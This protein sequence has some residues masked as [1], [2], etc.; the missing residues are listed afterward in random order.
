MEAL[1]FC[2]RVLF[3]AYVCSL[4]LVMFFPFFFFFFFFFFF[5]IFF[6]LFVNSFSFRRF[7]KVSVYIFLVV[8]NGFVHR[9]VCVFLTVFG[10][11]C[12]FSL[13]LLET[14]FQFCS[15]FLVLIWLF[16]SLLF[17][18]EPRVVLSSMSGFALVLLL[19]ICLGCSTSSGF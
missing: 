3:C 6:L 19:Y 16:C 10:G 14:F 13:C 12:A 15:A 18:V 9:C 8:V 5:V 11:L 2:C 7:L 1:F 4:C 17:A